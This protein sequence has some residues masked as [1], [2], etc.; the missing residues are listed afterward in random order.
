MTQTIMDYGQPVKKWGGAWEYRLT[1]KDI[2][3][4]IAE[5]KEQI[6]LLEKSAGRAVVLSRDGVVITVYPLR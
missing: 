3:G 4:P 5:L 6:Q 1:K 2:E